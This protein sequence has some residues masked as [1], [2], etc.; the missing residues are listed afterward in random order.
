MCSRGK[1]QVVLQ[2]DHLFNREQEMETKKSTGSR[3]VRC[4]YYD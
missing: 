2:L 4:S 3:G 1:Q